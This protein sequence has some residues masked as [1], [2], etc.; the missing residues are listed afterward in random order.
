MNKNTNEHYRKVYTYYGRGMEFFP[1]RVENVFQI[2]FRCRAFNIHLTYSSA[3]IVT[4][5][6]L[7][8]EVMGHT[9]NYLPLKI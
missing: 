3:K 8:N 6:A 4:L 5:Q 7:I 9:V 1:C 2:F